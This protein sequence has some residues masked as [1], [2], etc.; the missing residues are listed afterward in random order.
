M[1]YG[2][3]YGMQKR[4]QRFLD[5]IVIS[6]MIVMMVKQLKT[7]MVDYYKEDDLKFWKYN[8]QQIELKSMLSYF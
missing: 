2:V 8:F 4:N 3:T 5:R 7:H 1:N 6:N